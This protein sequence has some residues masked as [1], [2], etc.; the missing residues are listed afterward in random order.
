MFDSSDFS[1]IRGI[2][3]DAVKNSGI[4]KSGLQ[5]TSIKEDGSVVTQTDHFL[6]NTIS[7]KLYDRWPDIPFMGEEM[8]HEQQVDIVNAKKSQFW[9][10]DPLDGTTNFSMGF[11]FYG[12]SLALIKNGEAEF[13]IVYDPIRDECFYAISGEGAF[14]NNQRIKTVSTGIELGD[15]VA[16]VDLKRLV[17]QLA[18][19]L[20]RFPPYRA[21]RNLG[22]CVLEWCW[23][24]SGRIQLY[25][26]GGQRMWDYAAGSLILHEAGGVFSTLT[27]NTLNCKVFTKRSAV[28][29]INDELYRDWFRWLRENDNRVAKL[30]P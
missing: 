24:A 30:E 22:A 8:A 13:G 19:R 7:K 25:V 9:T 26:H 10:L 15:C 14:L 17:G 5:E 4:A 2:V 3:I 16:S 12:V 20:V 29:A 23:V 21:Q 27:G 28:A 11:P 18:D 6:Q 1:I